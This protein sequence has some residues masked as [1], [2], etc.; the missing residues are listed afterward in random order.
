METIVGA[1]D[2]ERAA[3]ELEVGLDI[4][5]LEM[6][7]Q[8]VQEIE[9]AL[10]LLEAGG[11][12][13]C[14]DCDEPILASRLRARP[15]AVRCRACQEELEGDRHGSRSTAA[16]ASR[17]DWAPLGSPPRPGRRRGTAASVARALSYGGVSL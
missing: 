13:R 16:S 8:Q 1:D 9:T 4:A 14:V 11:Y 17:S 10:R 12:G 15:F 6:R 5:L 7:S 3:Q 2:E